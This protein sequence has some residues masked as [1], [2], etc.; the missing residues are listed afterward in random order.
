MFV[1]PLGYGAGT[2]R[3]YWGLDSQSETEPGSDPRVFFFDLRSD[4]PGT[5]HLVPWSAPE[6]SDA[7]FWQRREAFVRALR[8]FE[9]VYGPQLLRRPIVAG[10][11]S[12]RT[13]DG[14]ALARYRLRLFPLSDD[15]SVPVE[16]LALDSSAV[17]IARF[18]RI[19]G[20]PERLIV[21]AFVGDPF[22]T[23]YETQWPVLEKR[24]FSPPLLEWKP[25]TR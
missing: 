8:P 16:V 9:E 6:I 3:V 4:T 19:P 24:G 13:W 15:V 1:V 20:R 11:D 22:E 12:I 5:A 25:P 21:I 10:V 2:E 17:S 7:R 14:E 18:L 23:T